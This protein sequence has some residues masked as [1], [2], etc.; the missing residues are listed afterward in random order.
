MDQDNQ[1]V[2]RN[3][4]YLW[5]LGAVSL[6]VGFLAT[7]IP[8]DLG[9]P[10]FVILLADLPTM[11]SGVIMFAMAHGLYTRMLRVFGISV[12]GMGW[13]F[14]GFA[15]AQSPYSNLH[16]FSDYLKYGGATIALVCM[17]YAGN[18]EPNLNDWRKAGEQGVLQLIER[19]H[20]PDVERRLPA[21][22]FLGQLG[23]SRAVEPLIQ[24][25]QDPTPAVRAAAA[26]ALGALGDPRAVL[27]LQQMQQHDTG[28]S[29]DKRPLKAIATE[30]IHRLHERE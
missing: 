15:I 16:I 5:R 11:A 23:D 17:F 12:C 6:F 4:V 27:A 21:A 9:I 13:F 22:K 3:K 26:Q 18:L 24:A 2:P 8:S 30:A 20:D 25:L 29:P 1:I 10:W 19:L 28:V 7:L 14:I